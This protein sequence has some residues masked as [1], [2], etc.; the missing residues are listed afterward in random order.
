MFDEDFKCEFKD[1]ESLSLNNEAFGI[2]GKAKKTIKSLT[3]KA[4]EN[5]EGDFN[6]MNKSLTFLIQDNDDLEVLTKTIS[7]SSFDVCQALITQDIITKPD[8]DPYDYVGQL[9]GL[10]LR[11]QKL[12]FDYDYIFTIGYGN[13]GRLFKNLYSSS[14][15]GTGSDTY[16][17]RRVNFYNFANQDRFIYYKASDKINVVVYCIYKDY[18]NYEKYFESRAPQVL[19]NFVKL[20]FT[21]QYSYNVYRLQVAAIILFA[22]FDTLAITQFDKLFNQFIPVLIK[23]ASFSAIADEKVDE[24][25]KT[26]LKYVKGLLMASAQSSEVSNRTL[27]D[28]V[29]SKYK[30]ETAPVAK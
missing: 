25:A 1:M 15:S 6:K 23:K 9:R 10:I 19:K 21:G 28:G 16:L 24:L 4:N 18:E 30:P 3:H 5:S 12:D 20:H 22:D 2:F 7:D 13:D 27:I 11:L 17:E 14:D 29:I 8:A 26:G